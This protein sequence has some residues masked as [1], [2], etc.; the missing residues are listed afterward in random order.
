MS[1]SAAQGDEESTS[2]AQTCREVRDDDYYPEIM[3][4]IA[5]RLAE[6]IEEG[7]IDG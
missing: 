1:E 5:G 4:R 3:R 2:F 7:R 6:A